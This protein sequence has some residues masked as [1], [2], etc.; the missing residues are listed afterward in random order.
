MSAPRVAT[1]T[2]SDTR[3]PDD[4]Q[5][6][7][8]LRALCVEVGFRHVRHAIVRES[9]PEVRAALEALAA[10]SEID[11]VL[12]T[13]GTGLGPRDRTI[14]VLEPLFTKRLTGFG[15]AFRRLS[16]DQV[17]A[18]SLLS[19]ASAGCID[20][21]LVFALPGSPK[22]LGLAVRELI[23]PMLGHALALRRGETAH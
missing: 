12:T 11:A 21:V 9:E 22:A 1:V 23:A 3:G 16:W 4:D 8:V 13:G 6:G 15:E 17:G 2:F 7:E 5:G 20:R 10:D 18:R 19:N 14:E